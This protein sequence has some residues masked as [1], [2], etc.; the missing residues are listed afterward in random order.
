MLLVED[1]PGISETVEIALSRDGMDCLVARTGKEALAKLSSDIQL[2][3]LDV[4]L[5]DASGFDVLKE[6]R[7]KSDTPVI[8]LTARNEEIDRI[9]GLELGADD[10]VSKPFSPRELGARIKAILRRSSKP[11]SESGV[12]LSIAES[13]SEEKKSAM[14]EV[15]ATSKDPSGVPR[16]R[17]DEEQCVIFFRGFRLTLSR[18]EYRILAL[19][20]RHPGWVF[21]REKIMDAVWEEPEESFDR[22]VDAHI[23]N[24]RA[25]LKEIS[26]EQDPIET[27]RGLGYS[28]RPL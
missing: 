18:Y 8:M 23:K 22:S 27:R 20:I 3:I 24:I 16:F 7:K 10:Y 13:Q 4:G 25:K 21:S 1:E 19:F 11:G 6:I 5:P 14:N 26:P 12:P 15:P 2:I 28:L 17:I 9:L